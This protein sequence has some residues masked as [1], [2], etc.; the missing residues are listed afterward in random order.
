MLRNVSGVCRPKRP[1]ISAVHDVL[2]FI[3]PPFRDSDSGEY[4]MMMA[5]SWRR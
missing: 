3:V 2:S 4:V 5:V 1:W